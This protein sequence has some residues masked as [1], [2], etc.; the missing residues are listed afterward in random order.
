MEFGVE[1]REFENERVRNGV[2][3]T[4]YNPIIYIYIYDLRGKMVILHTKNGH[5]AVPNG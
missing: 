4:N 5:I 2:E 1:S 3:S